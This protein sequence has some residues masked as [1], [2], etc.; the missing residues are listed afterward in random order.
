MP[1]LSGLSI[2]DLNKTLHGFQYTS[3]N[4]EKL[5][6][7]EYT[8]VQMVADQT[9]SVLSFKNDLEKMLQ[10]SSEACKRSPRA[11][12][13]LY[14]TTAFNAPLS[15]STI[16]ELHGFT[17]LDQMDTAKFI[18]ALNP[19]GGTPLV[20]ATLE[21]VE[22]LYD[23]GKKLYAKKYICN[24][25]LFILTDGEENASDTSHTTGMIKDTIERICKERILESI[26]TIL[27]GVND[28]Q[29]YFKTKLEQFKTEAG[30][31]EYI[32]I[33]E[34]TSGKLAKL[35][36][37]VSQSVSSQS[38]ALGSGGPSQPLSFKF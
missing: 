15:G 11:N 36:Q 20:D 24:G 23:M 7:M 21:A 1:K 22:A 38:Q 5:G 26:R 37:F 9:G 12:N 29:V 27:I 10:V 8:L 33:G 14:R 35:A 32:S 2:D 19:D 18:G 16:T 25:I 13:L 17:L 31:D 30:I 3:I 4:I 6:A 28:T 34:A